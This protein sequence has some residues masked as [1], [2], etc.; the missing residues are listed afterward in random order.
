MS[1]RYGNILAYLSI[2]AYSK[3]ICVILENIQRICLPSLFDR[4]CT[5]VMS[6]HDVFILMSVF[7]DNYVEILSNQKL[8]VCYLGTLK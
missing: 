3:N 4:T 2:Q 1:A 7:Y 8:V 5:F 6:I